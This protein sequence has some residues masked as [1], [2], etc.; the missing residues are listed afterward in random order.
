MQGLHT[1]DKTYLDTSNT[2]A[3]AM[4]L[5]SQSGLPWWLRG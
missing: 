2:L 5:R 4:N 3:F 1:K